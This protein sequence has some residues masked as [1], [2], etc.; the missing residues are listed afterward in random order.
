MTGLRVHFGDLGNILGEAPDANQQ[1]LQRRHV[2]RGGAS[3]PEEQG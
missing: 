3:V 2:D 1:S